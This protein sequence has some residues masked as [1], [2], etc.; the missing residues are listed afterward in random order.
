MT[1]KLKDKFD[2]KP[3]RN[4]RPRVLIDLDGVVRDFVGSLIKVYKR[5]HPDH[6]VLNVNSRKLEDFFPIG[7]GVYQ[8]MEPG[9]IEE[10]IEE[11]LPYRG[12]IEALYEWE[13]E[14]QI[15]IVTAQ[16][17]YCKASTF[18]WI[19]KNKIPTNEVHISY[20][21]SNIEGI[22]LLD[23]FVDNLEEFAETGRMAVCLDQPWNQQW[24]GPRVKTIN[25]FFLLLK[26]QNKV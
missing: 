11:A 7:P 5:N 15:V 4:N 19:G 17:D 22:A 1:R 25:D 16:P 23:D 6:E 24:K 13:N 3:S 2:I 10:I 18:T 12:A 8:F 9:Y 14:F 26:K 21:K 20:Y